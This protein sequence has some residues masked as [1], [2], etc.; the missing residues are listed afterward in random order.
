MG[1]DLLKLDV[2]FED[3]PKED[4]LAALAGA[5]AKVK[6]LNQKGMTGVEIV[7]AAVLAANALAN[8]LLK[9]LPL[10]KCGI[11]VDTRGARVLTRKDCKLPRGSV[12]I[13][14]KKG[15]EVKL[16]QPSEIELNSTIQALLG[17]KK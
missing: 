4:V 1:E 2:S 6:E 17:E 11:V 15:T 3:E 5:G 14:G 8:L 12:L 16:Q 7:V 10:W 9:F 13:V